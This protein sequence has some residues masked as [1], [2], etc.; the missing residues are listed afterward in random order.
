MI[1]KQVFVESRFGSA[2][3]HI[4]IMCGFVFLWFGNSFL[5][6]PLPNKIWFI[7]FGGT[8]AMFLMVSSLQKRLT[9]TCDSVGCEVSSKMF[10]QTV[11]KTYSFKWSEVTDTK[12]E[13]FA[14]LGQSPSMFFWVVTQGQAKRLLRRSWFASDQLK[15]FVALVNQAT[16]HLP[17]VWVTEETTRQA[18]EKV[19]KFRKVPRS[20]GDAG[21]TV[22][23][24]FQGLQ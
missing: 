12:F 13:R 2:P 5:P 20:L 1:Q 6:E 17:Y 9:L 10:W 15:S 19:G 24:T 4:L 18:I 23:S 11:G 22:R 16:P 21:T 8:Y 3:E 14:T 7:L